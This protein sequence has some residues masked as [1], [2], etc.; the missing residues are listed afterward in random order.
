VLKYN[1]LN[2]LGCK[3]EDAFVVKHLLLDV[4]SYIKTEN[5]IKL[6]KSKVN[7]LKSQEKQ[8]LQG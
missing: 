4:A 1:T 7:Y 2:D 8:E 5:F 6:S 3:V